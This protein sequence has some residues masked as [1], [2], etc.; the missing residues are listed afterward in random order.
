[1]EWVGL[2]VAVSGTFW[3]VCAY[4]GATKGGDHLFATPACSTI[5]CSCTIEAHLSRIPLIQPAPAAHSNPEKQ[6]AG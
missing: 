5:R 2:I 6:P 3:S 4:N 1:M